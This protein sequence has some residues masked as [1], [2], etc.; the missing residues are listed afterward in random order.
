MA[1]SALDGLEID[2]DLRWELLEGLALGNKVTHADIDEA[3][4]ADNTANG[5]Q[6]AARARATF[7]TAEAK[8]AAFSPRW[9]TRTACRTPSCATLRSGTST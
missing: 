6:A 1:P 8:L 3:L 2:T 9:S 7:Q 4:A 5:Q